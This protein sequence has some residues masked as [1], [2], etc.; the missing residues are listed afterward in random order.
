MSPM[1]TGLLDCWTAGEAN[2]AAG[3][4]P[5]KQQPRKA[6][7]SK[8]NQYKP[9]VFFLLVA[10]LS[11]SFSCGL[12]RAMSAVQLN[13][14]KRIKRN[15]STLLQPALSNITHMVLFGDIGAPKQIM[16]APGGLGIL[17][18]PGAAWAAPSKDCKT[19]GCGEGEVAYYIIE[20]M[21]IFQSSQ[22]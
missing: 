3:P 18:G 20:F 7:V 8:M 5:H 14:P 2:V 9:V 1:Q 12:D 6:A 16:A 11:V 10:N 13:P 21:I 22:A 4:M 17:G 15:P 19:A